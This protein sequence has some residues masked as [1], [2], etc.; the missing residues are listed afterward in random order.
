[1]NQKLA[2][3]VAEVFG[4]SPADIGPQTGPDQVSA[5][6]SIG[7]LRLVSAVECAFGVTLDLEEIA[8]MD[9]V[10]MLATILERKLGHRS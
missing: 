9:S 2:M 5:W 6:D 3:V 10:G 1:M 7:Q 4:V 8:S